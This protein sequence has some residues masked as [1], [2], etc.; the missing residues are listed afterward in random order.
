MNQMDFQQA[1][2][3]QQY[4]WTKELARDA[5]ERSKYLS[6]TA[7][8][9]GIRDMKAAGINPILAYKQ[10]GASTPSVGM[11]SVGLQSGAMAPVSDIMT[12]AINT[13]TQVREA[14]QRIAESEQRIEKS[15]Q[16]MNLSKA[17]EAQARA[18]IDKTQEE[19]KQ[20]GA[21][22]GKIGVDTQVQQ[23]VKS[24]KELERQGK[25]LDLKGNPWNIW[26]RMNIG[27]IEDGNFSAELK[28]DVM[29][30][31]GLWSG[32]SQYQRFFGQPYQNWWESLK[33]RPNQDGRNK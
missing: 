26:K 27:I 30:Q 33:K 17:Q 11:G 20:I 19:I 15:I 21:M 10:G 2:A 29:K 12:P 31:L 32:Y 7:W 22:T 14:S 18:I 6:D 3:K 13:A 16:D 4:D 8:V 23:I 25:E 1:S 28:E 5:Y 24:I 9:R